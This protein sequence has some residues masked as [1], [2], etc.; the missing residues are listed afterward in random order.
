MGVCILALS[1][2]IRSHEFGEPGLLLA[3]NLTNMYH[4][5]DMS[6]SEQPANSTESELGEWE[7]LGVWG[8]LGFGFRVSGFG[9][10]VWS[11]GMGV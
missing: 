11:W 7:L 10:W 8:Y 6:K 1:Q 2:S 5:P 3:P 9:C 4:T